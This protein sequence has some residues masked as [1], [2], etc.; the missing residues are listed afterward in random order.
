MPLQIPPPCLYSWRPSN[1]ASQ[2]ET[3]NFFFF[4]F[5]LFLSSLS[6]IFP[7]QR[8]APS[9]TRHVSCAAPSN[10][11]FVV[12]FPP[13]SGCELPSALH[14]KSTELGGSSQE[15]RDLTGRGPPRSARRGDRHSG[16]AGRAARGST[17]GVQRPA[18]A[19]QLARTWPEWLAGAPSAA[20]LA[21]MLEH[22]L[23]GG[24]GAGACVMD[25]RRHLHAVAVAPASCAPAPGARPP[26]R[27][28]RATTCRRRRCWHQLLTDAVWVACSIWRSNSRVMALA[29]ESSNSSPACSLSTAANAPP[30]RCGRRRTEC[31]GMKSR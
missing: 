27:A 18:Q 23:L 14:Y 12:T 28:P 24:A 16:N 21:R 19:P 3:H 4:F 11:R 26:R 17:Q 31:G 20:E 13:P 1:P 9:A 25:Q 2:H 5:I 7:N 30:G 6:R 10:S 8:S 22:H 29:R 15:R